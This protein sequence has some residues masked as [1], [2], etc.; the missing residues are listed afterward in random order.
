M[1]H[2]AANPPD[3][4]ADGRHVAFV[5]PA[6]P[7]SPGPEAT[8]TVLVWDTLTDVVEP[9]PAL[10]AGHA[11]LE[12]AISG[13]G[14]FV[15]YTSRLAT[16]STWSGGSEMQVWLWDRLAGQATSVSP[17]GVL[18]GFPDVSADGSTAVFTALAVA[19]A[20]PPNGAAHIH[21]YDV[22]TGTRERI[23][24]ALP[25]G[26]PGGT[27]VN[28]AVSAD[29]DTVVFEFQW[30]RHFQLVVWERATGTTTDL[31]PPLAAYWHRELAISGDGSAVVFNA[32]ASAVVPGDP[33]TGFD[34][35]LLERDPGRLVRVTDGNGSSSSTAISADGDVVTFRSSS[36]N[37][38]GPDGQG[39]DLF[40]WDRTGQP[41]R[42]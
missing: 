2:D 40:A 9:A 27:R 34:V 4:S 23:P 18:S 38:L 37:L 10:P 33:D 14:R 15:T 3:L 32:P 7:A 41:G 35:F 30:T 8:W 21:T 13:D 28:P 39:A 24:H 22:A 29:G 17:P 12:P 5:G 1:S 25:P 20:D 36:S 11:V 16:S 19:G 31:G 6:D 26:I 42:P